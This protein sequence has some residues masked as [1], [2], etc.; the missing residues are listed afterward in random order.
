MSSYVARD[1]TLFRQQGMARFIPQKPSM[2]SLRP[3]ASR[4]LRSFPTAYIPAGVLC[5]VTTSALQDIRH[6]GLATVYAHCGG[7]A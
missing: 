6:G 2:R 3:C 1:P 4:L 5:D 7:M